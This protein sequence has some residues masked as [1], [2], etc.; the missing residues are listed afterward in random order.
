MPTI[1]SRGSV[2]ALTQT[3]WVKQRIL[4]RFPDVQ[5]TVKVIKT[6]ADKDMSSSLR[7]GSGIG[8]FVKEIEE[9]LLAREIDIAVHS[10]KDVPTLIPD[11]LEIGAVPEREDARDALI[12]GGEATSISEL[13]RGA[14]VGTGSVRRHVQLLAVRPDLRTLDIR[15][16]VDTRLRKLASGAYDAIILACAG[17]NR[18]GL[19][20]KITSRLSFDQ[21]LPAA[22]QGALALEIRRDDP[23]VRPLMDA[24][25]H[26][27]TAVAVSAERA[28]LHRMGGGCNVPVAVHADC[29]QNSVSID[30][31]VASIDGKRIIRDR[32]T[33]DAG[34][35]QEAASALADRILAQG[36]DAIIKSLS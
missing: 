10:M 2:L 35:A 31:L 20:D 33:A 14:I 21:M 29:G 36:G 25:N 16:N 6:S 3:N 11:E 28:F 27:P 26:A 17:L 18:L 32:T 34:R 30:G 7:S 24:L 15:G 9:A 23:N 12:T 1:G 4:S 13:A 22:G 19:G 5:L 8:V